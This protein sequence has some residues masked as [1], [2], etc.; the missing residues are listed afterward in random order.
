[1]IPTVD[2]A[3]LLEYARFGYVFPLAYR[4]KK[5]MKDWEYGKQAHLY[6]TQDPAVIK[7]WYNNPIEANGRVFSKRPGR[8]HPWAWIPEP[9]IEEPVII[10][11][12]LVV[13][14]ENPVVIAEP[15]YDD[16]DFDFNFEPE[17]PAVII[18]KKPSKLGKKLK[19]EAASEQAI[20]ALR[21]PVVSSETMEGT[22]TTPDA[23]LVA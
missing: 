16:F 3:T 4:A 17:P 1:M 8:E 6:R 10:A 12:P 7:H 15:V 2:L 23:D 5:P 9:V 18:Q 22:Q 13:V 11:V 19:V 21:R 14:V 20:A